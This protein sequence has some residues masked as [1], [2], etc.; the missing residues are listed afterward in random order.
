MVNAI[1][2]TEANWWEFFSM[3]GETH[4]ANRLT[5]LGRLGKSARYKAVQRA[6]GTLAEKASAFSQER[7]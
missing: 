3:A 1:N 2:A 5:A 7:M 6:P 4:V